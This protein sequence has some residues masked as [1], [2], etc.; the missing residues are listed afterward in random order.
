MDHQVS[1]REQF[2]WDSIPLGDGQMLNS[3]DYIDSLIRSRVGA[4]FET[5][6]IRLAFYWRVMKGEILIE[7][8]QNALDEEDDEPQIDEQDWDIVSP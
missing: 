1:K 3:L 8:E 4:Y 2:C 6:A 5:L 7:V